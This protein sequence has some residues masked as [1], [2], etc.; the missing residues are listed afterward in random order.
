MQIETLRSAHKYHPNV[1][2]DIIASTNP[3][4]AV[5]AHANTAPGATKLTS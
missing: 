4:G 3:V 1:N 5:A 2:N